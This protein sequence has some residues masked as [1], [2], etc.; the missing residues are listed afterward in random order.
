MDVV[1]GQCAK[2]TALQVL[3][4]KKYRFRRVM[5]ENSTES[6]KTEGRLVFFWK[7][8]KFKASKGSEMHP[9]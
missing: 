7:C 3:T 1:L 8:V 9:D 5:G 2:R 6:R 4:N